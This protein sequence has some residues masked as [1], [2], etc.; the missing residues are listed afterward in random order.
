LSTE[1]DH[2]YKHFYELYNAG[3]W[4]YEPREEV[5]KFKKVQKWSDRKRG[6]PMKENNYIQS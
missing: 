4:I 2:F 3:G 5:P 1:T 6:E